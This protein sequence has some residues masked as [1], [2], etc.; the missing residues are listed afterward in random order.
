M[1]RCTRKLRQVL[2]EA[3]YQRIKEKS[4][5]SGYFNYQFSRYHVMQYEGKNNLIDLEGIYP[6]DGMHRLPDY[7]CHFD[8]KDY[9]EFIAGLCQG[10]IHQQVGQSR[11]PTPLSGLEFK[12]MHLFV[13]GGI[14]LWAQALDFFYKFKMNYLK[15]NQTHLIQR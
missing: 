5:K 13:M 12:K 7:H 6:L 2:D 14:F 11:V 10:T 9:E 8:S 1:R 4:I 15:I 3:Y